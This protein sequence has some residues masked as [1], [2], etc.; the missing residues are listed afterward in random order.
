MDIDKTGHG[1]LAIEV[2]H[3]GVDSH[4]LTHI[5]KRSDR[6]DFALTDRKSLGPWLLGIA[7]VDAPVGNDAISHDARLVRRFTSQQRPDRNSAPRRKP[8][9]RACV[10]NQFS[11]DY[12]TQPPDA[13]PNVVR[14]HR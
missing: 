9:D 5:F 6:T 2:D 13:S 4:G 14:G 8:R 1:E 10:E 7:C 12:K 11:C 3:L